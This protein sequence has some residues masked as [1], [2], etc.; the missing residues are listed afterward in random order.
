MFLSWKTTQVQN[1]L[2]VC[3]NVN[4]RDLIQLAP[5]QLEILRI[6]LRALSEADM[7]RSFKVVNEV[8][9]E[10]RLRATFGVAEFARTAREL[11]KN[12]IPSRS[13]RSKYRNVKEK[14][15]RNFYIGQCMHFD[16]RWKKHF[17]QLWN[18]FKKKPFLRK[19]L[20][21]SEKLK[22]HAF[23]FNRKWQNVTICRCGSCKPWVDGGLK[24]TTS[25]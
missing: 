14:K 7:E 13:A 17:S 9:E 3:R 11:W 24:M 5:E 16:E 25:I 22:F 2:C 6:T 4:W 8:L 23:I 10:Q 15:F 18:V 1:P 12:L 19:F 21:K 20:H